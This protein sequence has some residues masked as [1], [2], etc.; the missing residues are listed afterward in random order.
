[1]KKRVFKKYIDLCDRIG[2]ANVTLSKL[3]SEL[4]MSKANL[5]TYFPDKESIIVEMIE[6][7]IK[8]FIKKMSDS[9]NVIAD[10]VE[11]LKSFIMTNVKIALEKEVYLKV[12]HDII[13]N[14]LIADKEKLYNMKR[15][16]KTIKDILVKILYDGKNKNIFCENVDEERT[17]AYILSVLRGIFFENHFFDADKRMF[18]IEEWEKYGEEIFMLIFKGIKK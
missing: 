7:Y 10:P 16:E 11:K 2:T 9:D 3:A 1:L 12:V 5:Y 6:Y 8:D 17:S 13:Q 15:F 14:K 18:N 4:D